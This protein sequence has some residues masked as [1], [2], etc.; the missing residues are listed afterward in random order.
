MDTKPTSGY[1]RE[2]CNRLAP[3]YDPLVRVTML[4]V[5]G[6]RRIRQKIIN[7]L[8]L[9]P[10]DHVR[11][12]GC[13]TGTLAVMMA[14]T[15]G[16]TGSV[17]GIDLSPRM[18]NVAQRKAS[19]PQLTF[20][21]QNAEDLQFPDGYLDKVTAVY[22]LHEMLHEARQNTL[23]EIYRVL[24]PD[25]H[26]LV[27]DIHQPQGRL[28]HA[29]FRLLM[30]GEGETAWDLLAHGLLNEIQA[31]GFENPQQC[32]IIRDLVPVTLA[33]KNAIRASQSARPNGTVVPIAGREH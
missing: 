29:L 21:K 12:A 16:S 7:H 22:V 25:G 14:C 23:R 1:F 19:L 17:V 31:T 6:E 13:G 26:L 3:Y 15:I 24:K 32:F 27:V 8:E 2:A 4:C 18:L 28:R 33:S 11:D 20:L 5:G 30:L 10:A 9:G